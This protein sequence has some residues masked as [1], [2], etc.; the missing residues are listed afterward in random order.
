MGLLAFDCQQ[1]SLAEGPRKIYME[2][3]VAGMHLQ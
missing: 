1:A 3:P 2:H